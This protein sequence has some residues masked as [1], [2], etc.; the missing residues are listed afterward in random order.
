MPFGTDPIFFDNDLISS[1]DLS[2]YPSTQEAIIHEFNKK[3]STTLQ[4]VGKVRLINIDDRD[5][6]TQLNQQLASS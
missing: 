1:V 5:L 3:K 2:Q 6:E 4:I